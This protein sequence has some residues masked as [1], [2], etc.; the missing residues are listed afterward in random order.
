[1]GKERDI[2]Q[3]FEENK[4]EL[5]KLRPTTSKVKMT[6]L[7]E[8]LNKKIFDIA[9]SDRP[10]RSKRFSHA[11]VNFKIVDDMIAIVDNIILSNIYYKREMVK[12]GDACIYQN[13]LAR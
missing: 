5:I 7:V 10:L 8:D 1:M 6:D 3:E 4:L 11:M 9:F 12:T 2:K 13:L